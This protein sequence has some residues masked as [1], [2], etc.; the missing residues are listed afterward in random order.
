VF[1]GIVSGA[2][3]TALLSLAKY[4]ADPENTLP[5]IVFWLLGSLAQI[6][7]AALWVIGPVLAGDRH[8]GGLR[9]L[10]RPAGAF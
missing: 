8:A 2:L 3:C 6:D 4:V 10:S 5:D 9:A 7:G 1:G